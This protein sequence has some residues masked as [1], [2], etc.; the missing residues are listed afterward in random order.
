MITKNKKSTDTVIDFI[1]MNYLKE[2]KQMN[3][4]LGK[5]SVGSAFNPAKDTESFINILTD[6][7][8]HTLKCMMTA[9][10]FNDLAYKEIE[11]PEKEID[12]LVKENDLSPNVILLI[13][14]KEPHDLEFYQD[15]VKYNSEPFIPPELKKFFDDIKEQNLS[16][17]FL[18]VKDLLDIVVKINTIEVLFNISLIQEYKVDIDK[19]LDIKQF[20]PIKNGEYDVIY[21]NEFNLPSVNTILTPIY[22]FNQNSVQR[23]VYTKIEYNYEKYNI[24]KDLYTPKDKELFTEEHFKDIYKKLKN[25]NYDINSIVDIKMRNFMKNKLLRDLSKY[26][27]ELLKNRIQHI[28]D[29]I[30][31][32]D[33]KLLL[34][35][36]LKRVPLFCHKNDDL[37]L[38]KMDYAQYE[39]QKLLKEYN[40]ISSS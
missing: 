11:L 5:S 20:Y 26:V 6:K 29:N 2:I 35:Y 40:V 38:E 21:N 10:K 37:V 8:P 3:D 22:V 32:C 7:D 27:E 19:I 1:G 15:A 9:E 17:P 12:K 18:D 34:E 30:V 28:I 14:N 13:K 33:S 24:N 36:K 4:I 23:K 25:I 16:I 31:T 39:T